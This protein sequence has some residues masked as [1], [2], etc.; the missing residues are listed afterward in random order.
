MLSKILFAFI[1]VGSVVGYSYKMTT[2]SKIAEMRS[3]LKTQASLI[4]A[5]EIREA[6]QVRTIEALQNNL[7]KTTEALNIMS[8][9]NAEIE[10]EAQRYLSI[11]ARHDLSKLAAAKPGLIETR[12]NKGTL[13]VFRTIE[14]DTTDIDAIDN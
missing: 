12:I 1:I 6:E 9:K 14:K 11:F 3:Q 13:D 8:T 2:E 7:Q 5:F 10:A 4:T